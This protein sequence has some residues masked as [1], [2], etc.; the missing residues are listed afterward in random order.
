MA[1]LILFQGFNTTS[2]MTTLSLLVGFIVTFLGVHLLD[3]SRKAQDVAWV[4]TGMV[5]PQRSMGRMNT[6]GGWHASGGVGDSE[7]VT[8]F[9]TYVGDG[10]DPGFPLTWLGMHKED[11]GHAVVVVVTGHITPVTLVTSPA[12]WH[13]ACS[14][15]PARSGGLTHACRHVTLTRD[16]M[17]GPCT[18]PEKVYKPWPFC[19]CFI[20]VCPNLIVSYSFVFIIND[21]YCEV[22]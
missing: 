9:S 19:R 7:S 1:L 3:F 11:E 8:L 22:D 18:A 15:S 4:E 14:G 17:P 13:P 10:V 16:A 20:W 2:G 6:D 12:S 21:Y 5:D